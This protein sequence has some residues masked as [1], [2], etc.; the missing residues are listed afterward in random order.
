MKKDLSETIFLT[1]V[2]QIYTYTLLWVLGDTR[3]ILN[4]VM[5]QLK[6]VAPLDENGQPLII[7]PSA[8]CANEIIGR[9]G[10]TIVQNAITRNIKS[11]GHYW[12]YVDVGEYK[13][14]NLS[15]MKDIRYS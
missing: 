4:N 7:F 14:Q 9:N 1:H 2:S 5:G 12:K 11:N 13:S 10:S 15:Y 8:S 6:P 3:N